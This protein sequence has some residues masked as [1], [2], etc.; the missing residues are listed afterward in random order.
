MT[1]RD[2][3]GMMVER[4]K[5]LASWRGVPAAKLNGWRVDAASEHGFM[6][7]SKMFGRRK[8]YTFAP[9][10]NPPSRAAIELARYSLVETE[11]D[12]LATT[13]FT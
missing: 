3:I 7:F 10:S 9:V 6:R 5:L 11:K 4:Q 8:A 13:P 12:L 2:R 1:A